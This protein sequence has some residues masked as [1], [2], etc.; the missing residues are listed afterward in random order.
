MISFEQANIL[1]IVH[2]FPCSSKSRIRELLETRY[3]ITVNSSFLSATVDGL[4]A[5]RY[6]LG[7]NGLPNEYMISDSGLGALREFDEMTETYRT[8]RESLSS[9][10]YGLRPSL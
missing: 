10:L 9:E 8:V 7:R 3:G 4:Y 1:M 6:L 2:A 5:A